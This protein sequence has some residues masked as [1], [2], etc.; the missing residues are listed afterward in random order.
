M[1][2]KNQ[3]QPPKE[4]LA[5]LFTRM[6]PRRPVLL[7]VLELCRNARNADEVTDYVNEAQRSNHSV[8]SPGSILSLLEKAGGI[9]RVCADGEAYPNEPTEPERVTVDGVEYLRAATPAPIFWKTSNEGLNVLENDRPL[10]R[11]E[12]LFA[13]DADYLGVYKTTLLACSHEGGATASELGRA[14]DGLSI[15]QEPRLFAAHFTEKLERAGAIEWHDA[16]VATEVG[17]EALDML[18]DVQAA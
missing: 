7:G 10:E 12:E 4:R 13:C 6:A 16:W 8:Y 11:I 2:R 3:P 15:V 14:I 5:K 17:V 9:E 1:T 18:S